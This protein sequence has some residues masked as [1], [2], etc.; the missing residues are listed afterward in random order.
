MNKLE[1][2]LFR[3]DNYEFSVFGL[4]VS[5]GMCVKSLSFNPKINI[6]NYHF[7]LLVK[8]ITY[9]FHQKLRY[10]FDRYIFS[11][12]IVEKSF[13]FELLVLNDRWMKWHVVNPKINIWKYWFSLLDNE[14]THLYRQKSLEYL[15]RTYFHIIITKNLSV[16]T[17]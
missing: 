3:D 7:S 17:R 16:S 8:E 5:K 4:L 15:I 1:E 2:Y 9:L 6:R 13:A 12:K 10:Y 14:I 11:W